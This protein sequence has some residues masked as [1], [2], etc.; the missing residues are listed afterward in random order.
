MSD[1]YSSFSASIGHGRLLQ[2]GVVCGLNRFDLFRLLIE[3]CFMVADDTFEPAGSSCAAPYEAKLSL[4][5]GLYQV[6]ADLRA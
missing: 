1:H 3:S 4:P 2:Y 5:F 6:F